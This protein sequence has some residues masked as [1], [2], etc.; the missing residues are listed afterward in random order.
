MLHIFR[1][2]P[3]ALDHLNAVQIPA[4]AC[5]P[6]SPE[7][8]LVMNG[9][10]GH[11]DSARGSETWAVDVEQA[12]SVDA[13]RQ[14]QLFSNQSSLTDAA[15]LSRD[16]AGAIVAAS[17]RYVFMFGG[18][19]YRQFPSKAEA[20]A[21]SEALK[22]MGLGDVQAV[23]KYKDNWQATLSLDAVRVLDV[24]GTRRWFHLTRLGRPRFALMT[25]ASTSHAYSCGGTNG[26]AE[27]R[28]GQGGDKQN[29]QTCLVHSI[30]ELIRKADNIVQTTL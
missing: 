30:A 29:L 11:F 24:C 13:Q 28:H 20:I 15:S 9:R 21:G 3:V 12:A 6:E 7:R 10:H 2:L 18:V 4:R 19:H 16:A 5:G 22:K 25:C 1:R 23:R 8:I 27:R 14:W 17:G 26:R